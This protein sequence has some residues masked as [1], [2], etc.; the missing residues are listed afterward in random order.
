M[1]K[2]TVTHIIE[3]LGPDAICREVGVGHD[4]V[5]KAKTN[6]LFPASWYAQLLRMCGERGLECPLSAFKMR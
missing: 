6:G 3:A 4:S 2:Q 1:D 5:R